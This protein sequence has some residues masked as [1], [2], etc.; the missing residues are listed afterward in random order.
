VLCLVFG[1]SGGESLSSNSKSCLMPDFHFQR[2]CESS[3]N[4]SVL[5]TDGE[6]DI[7]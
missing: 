2:L 3:L 5:F 7:P 4:S 1:A 6:R